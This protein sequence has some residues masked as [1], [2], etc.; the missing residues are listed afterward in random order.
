MFEQ[1]AVVVANCNGYYIERLLSKRLIFN[2]ELLMTGKRQCIL[3][4]KWT[5]ERVL[6]ID[7]TF[8]CL[9]IVW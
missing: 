1:V 5:L 2:N 6:K 4:S 9:G 3:M 7:I 8:R